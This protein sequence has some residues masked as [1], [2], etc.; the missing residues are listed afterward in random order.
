M[1]NDG[2]KMIIDTIRF[3]YVVICTKPFNDSTV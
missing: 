3:A 1:K 2:W